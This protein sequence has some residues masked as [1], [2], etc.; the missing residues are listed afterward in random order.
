MFNSAL[1]LGY[2][3]I[4]KRHVQYLNLIC[5]LIDIVDLNDKTHDDL[6]NQHLNFHRSLNSFSSKV[7]LNSVAVI[8][9]WGPDHL[10]S[11]K[12]CITLGFKNI[13]LEKPMV[14]SLNNLFELKSLV[15]EHKL[16]VA[17]NQGWHYQDYAMKINSLAHK[18]LLGSPK[19][20]WVN[21]GARCIS[22]AGSHIIHLSSQIFK[23]K[24]VEFMGHGKSSFINPRNPN[25]SYYEGVFSVLYANGERLGINYTNNS[26]LSG[27]VQ[28]FWQESVGNFVDERFIHL[29][30]RDPNREFKHQITRYGKPELILNPKFDLAEAANGVSNFK[31]IY[32]KLYQN[33]I[34]DSLATFDKHF[35]SNLTMLLL[36][37]SSKIGKIIK[38]VEDVP[39]DIL[40]YDFRIS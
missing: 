17:V 10:D 8:S 39:K 6:K 9:N 24:P 20:I 4:G 29:A 16:K 13:V 33:N 37:A 23:S 5:D 21:G 15:Y 25:L 40:N 2:G 34:F 35:E 12:E 22:T 32:E 3:S 38:S 11:L 27:D 30:S 28:I 19:S 1:V 18:Y 26:S 14:S 31:Y 7:N 36:L